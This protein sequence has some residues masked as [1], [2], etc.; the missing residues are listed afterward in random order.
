MRPLT[1]YLPSINGMEHRL[2]RRRGKLPLS[3]P[4][5]VLSAMQREALVKT[6]RPNR[7]TMWNLAGGREVTEA[8]ARRLISSGRIVPLDPGLGFGEESQSFVPAPTPEAERLR[9]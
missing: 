7:P 8:V 9:R 5:A 2:G 6:F 4:E 3:Q 1:I